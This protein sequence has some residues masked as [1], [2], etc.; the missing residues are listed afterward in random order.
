MYSTS[1]LRM[2]L[3]LP[4]ICATLTAADASSLYLLQTGAVVE[5]PKKIAHGLH[6]KNH[7]HQ[8]LAQKLKK[9]KHVRNAQL[10][11]QAPTLPP[12][13]NAEA[14]ERET[15]AQCPACR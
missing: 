11:E 8:K 6:S 5:K 15:R 12:E 10:V 4:F 7:Q 9:E 2:L 3:I 13:V 14:Q 1:S